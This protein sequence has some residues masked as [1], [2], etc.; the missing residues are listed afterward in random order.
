M[1]SDHRAPP[2]SLTP[3]PALKGEA[4]GLDFFQ[5]LRRTEARH[6][7]RPRLGTATRAADDP[8]RLGQEPSTTFAPAVFA[9]FEAGREGKPMRMLVHFLGLLG[10][11][12][13]LP[14][15]LTEYV[16]DR[17]RNARDPTFARFLDVFN[18]RM[19]SL[20]YRGWAQ[21]QPTVS[22]DRPDEDRFGDYIGSLF[23]IGMP[24]LRRRDAMPDLAK[25]HFA[26]HLSCQAR[27]PEGL[28][29]ILAGFLR[30]PVTID[31]LI[32]H[33]L[34]LPRDCQ[35]R[36]GDSPATGALGLSATV[37]PRVWDRQ[38]KFRVR[39]G[40]LG[41]LDYERLLPGGDSLPRLVAV[42]RNYAGDQLSWDLNLVLKQAEVPSIRLGAAGRLGWSTWL[43]SR[44]LARDGD[45]L[46]LNAMAWQAD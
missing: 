44:P 4:F 13:P 45:D 46:L 42:V 3:E 2:D 25:L 34:A 16:R 39:L 10:P 11:N 20:F 21:A 37:G 38:S 33:W 26:G 8:V 43:T 15:H 9:R 27:H 6:P 29:S 40:P 22:F 36:L 12:G 17:L 1:A 24:S 32:G 23:G 31:E 30:L 14:L 35:W 7:E 41:L 18:H 19:L 28:R 5:T